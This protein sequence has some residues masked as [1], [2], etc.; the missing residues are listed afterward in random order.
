MFRL[1][2]YVRCAREGI[3]LSFR[4]F[5]L[6]PHLLKLRP[7]LL[8]EIGCDILAT[9][10]FVEFDSVEEN[11]I[12]L[13]KF[14]SPDPLTFPDLMLHL[15]FLQP[16]VTIEEVGREFSRLPSS[17]IVSWKRMRISSLEMKLASHVAIFFVPVEV[18]S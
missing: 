9:K 6:P 14:V 11:K 12:A 4:R 18:L 15:F 13:I 17:S 3:Y 10:G 2:W 1:V 7:N 5:G 8:N 16:S